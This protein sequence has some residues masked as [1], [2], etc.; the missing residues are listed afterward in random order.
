MRYGWVG[1]VTVRGT[2]PTADVAP[3]AN[4]LGKIKKIAAAM[5]FMVLPVLRS[6]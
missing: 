5:R 6:Q 3:I 4:T 2:T 1:G